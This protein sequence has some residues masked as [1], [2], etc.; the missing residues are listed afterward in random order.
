MGYITKNWSGFKNSLSLSEKVLDKVKPG[1]SLKNRLQ[2]SQ[3]KLQL[4]ISKLEETHKKLQLNH[5]HVFKKIV[6]AK[7]SRNESKARSYAIELQEL[8]KVK[9][10]IGGAKLAM[11]QIKIR[12]NTI[13]ELGD[14]VV[15]LSPCMSLIKGLA[16]SLSSFM[17]GI[18]TSMQ[19]MSNMLND[20]MSSSSL[21]AESAYV[22]NE[23]NQD[24]TAILEE[25]HTVLEGKTKSNMPEPPTANL[26][27]LTKETESLI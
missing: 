12:L 25:A 16:P 6:D 27:N 3:K 18:N 13:T 23:T 17:P 1:T 2:D 14:V 4:Q 8:R 15:T 21:P 5:D 19:D 26:R 9:K 11:E 7:M 10:M 24:I 20:L 22:P